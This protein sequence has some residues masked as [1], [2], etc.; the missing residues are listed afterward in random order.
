MKLL[1]EVWIDWRTR[2]DDD[3]DDVECEN[4]SNP[5]PLKE[6]QLLSPQVVRQHRHLYVSGRDQNLSIE[7]SEVVYGS[8]PQ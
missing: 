3:D 6:S 8:K 2:A 1:N 4:N 5:C 7:D